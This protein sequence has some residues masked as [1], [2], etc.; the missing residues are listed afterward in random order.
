MMLCFFVSSVI[1]NLPGNYSSERL[2]S[3]YETLSDVAYSRWFTQLM[4]KALFQ[5]YLKLFLRN[6]NLS[7]KE[8]T[9]TKVS[10]I[11]PRLEG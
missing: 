2:S 5:N 11:L 7:M 10:V 4:C 8:P 9:R 6:I 3:G 1:V